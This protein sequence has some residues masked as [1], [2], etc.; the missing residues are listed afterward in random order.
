MAEVHVSPGVYVR[1]R[2]FS[3]YVSS[4]GNSKLAL[5]GETKKG[6]AMTPMLVK[7]MGEF[8]EKFGKTDPNKHVGYCAQEYFKN[9][10]EAYIVRVLGDDLLRGTANEIIPLHAWDSTAA[11]FVCVATILAPQNTDYLLQTGVTTTANVGFTAGGLY[12]G[13]INL[14]NKSSASYIE[15]LFPRTQDLSIGNKLATQ[16]IFP[17]TIARGLTFSGTILYSGITSGNSS[18]ILSTEPLY[19]DGYSNAR[20]PLIVSSVP[21]V[22]SEGVGL[23]TLYSLSDGKDANNEIK[24]EIANIDIA[25][26][27]FDIYVRE[28]DDTNASRKILESYV[29]VTLD[30]TSTNYILKQ[31]GDSQDDSGDY[32]L[33]SNYIYADVE[34]GDLSNYVPGGFNRIVAP[35]SGSSLTAGEVAFPQWN[36]TTTYLTTTAVKRQCLGLNHATTDDDLLM[37]G[38]NSAWDMTKT[39]DHYLKGFHLQ[40]GASSTYYYSGS[41]GFT[42][43]T[44]GYEVTDAKFVV[45][46]LGGNDGWFWSAE[47][48]LRLLSGAASTSEETQWKSA[49]DTVKNTDEYDINLV[50]TP[51]IAINQAISTYAREMC[52]TR[53]DCLY[54]G[55]M[56]SN[57]TSVAQAIDATAAIDSSYAA[58]FWPYVQIWDSDNSRDVWIPPTAQALGAM[59]YTDSVS[60]PWWAPAGLNRGILTVNKAKYKLDQDDRDIL[61]SNKINPI[62][63]FPGQGIAIWGQKTLQTNTTALDRINVRRM[64]LYIEKVIAGASKYIVFQPNDETTWDHFKGL[65][66]PILDIVKIR[67]GLYDFRIIM[68]ETTNTDDLIDRNTMLGQIYIKPTKTAEAITI[69]FNI[70][71]HG[72][73]FTE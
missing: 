57:Y 52:E 65:V 37:I 27:K 2:D 58:T 73:V 30:P 38:N 29:G 26:N 22:S 64:M 70:M 55:D 32:A 18:S 50:A 3:Y 6:P 19:V 45:P 69:N 62:A 40:S 43:G 39:S 41:S 60:D 67:R 34:S 21:N 33:K 36:M 68:D 10:N 14:Y 54:I 49:I 53:A 13:T 9:A 56:P 63:T 5:I 7:N 72:A 47:T 48:R 8:R 71:P 20:T 59:A 28:I 42:S 16:H 51:G 61:Y 46:V 24:I 12:S 66:Q 17:T 23:F 35:V 15:T 1:E 11:A 25:N 4:I 44:G 31:I